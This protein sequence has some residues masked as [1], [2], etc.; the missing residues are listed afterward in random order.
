M[1]V[2]RIALSVLALAF[3]TA[4]ALAQF[5]PPGV[6]TCFAADGSKLGS[7]S[8]L[9]A[10]DYEWLNKSGTSVTGQVASAGTAVEALSGQLG[11]QHW[12][13][14]FS[15]DAGKTTFVFTTDGGQVTCE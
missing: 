5:P 15:T 12:N 8:L 7:L 4:P 2:M 1:L 10:G 6:Y 9:V 13:G 3:L 14:S 11:D